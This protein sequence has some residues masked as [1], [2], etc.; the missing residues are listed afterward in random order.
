MRLLDTYKAR[1]ARLRFIREAE[2]RA[3]R[4]AAQSPWHA[5]DH[6]RRVAR[7][8]LRLIDAG[9]RAEPDVL[10]VF[11]AAHDTQRH[12]DFSDAAHGPRAA[13]ALRDLAADGYLDWLTEEQLLAART[14]CEIHTSSP[15]GLADETLGACLD[16]DRL[17]HW[18]VGKTPKLE[19]L[20]TAEAPRFV[21]YGRRD[22]EPPSW[23]GLVRRF[24]PAAV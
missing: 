4:V 21:F 1:R 5:Q 18:R 19:Y 7:F 3:T 23:R 12:D 15:G 11:A 8:G 9:V 13:L 16:A 24:V 6:W 22:T 20:S 10:L 17:D 14:A 2:R